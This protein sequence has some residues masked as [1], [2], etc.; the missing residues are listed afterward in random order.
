MKGGCMRGLFI[1]LVSIALVSSPLSSLQKEEDLLKGSSKIEREGWIFLHLEGTPFQIGYQHGFFL[2]IYIDEAIKALSFYL[3]K[4]TGKKW[5][6]FKSVAK[7]FYLPKIP[8]EYLEEMKGIA[9]GAR[10][11]GVKEI[12]LE[13]IVAL[14]SWMETAWYYIPYIEPKKKGAPSHCSAF[15]AT[16][17]ATKDGIIVMA[18]NTWIDYVTGRFFNIFIDLKPKKGNRILMQSYPGFIHSGSDWYISSSGL[19]VTETTIVG[20]KGFNPNGTP[21]FVRARRAIQYANSIDEWVE[22]I[23][24]DNNGGYANS[25]LIGDRKTGEIACLELG[26]KNH[27]LK[28][29][30]NGYFAGSNIAFDEKVREETDLDYSDETTTGMAR[31]KRWKELLDSNYGKIDSNLAKS[32]ISDHFDVV[33]QKE[34]PSARTLC[35]H[36]ELD[37][38]GEPSWERPPYYPEGAVDAKVTDS[39]LAERMMSWAIFGHPCKLEFNSEKFLETKSQF[40]WMKDWLKDLPKNEWVL[41]GIK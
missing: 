36:I 29:T 1:F 30:K 38:K 32:F 25:W 37:P 3:E 12:D 17:D 10:A 33:L 21:E 40:K 28:R 8:Q 31:H 11:I 19:M 15:I 39:L 2:G 16:G 18:H 9:E 14:N 35:G 5:K 4:E 13:D 41:F 23:M 24:E 20:F 6:F 26:L 22:I 27:S 7:K 34:S